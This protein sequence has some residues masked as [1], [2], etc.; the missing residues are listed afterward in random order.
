MSSHWDNMSKIYL[1]SLWSREP[2]KRPNNKKST[3]IL[4]NEF[5]IFFVGLLQKPSGNHQGSPKVHLV[6]AGQSGHASRGQR[7]HQHRWW[8]GRGCPTASRLENVAS[9][10]VLSHRSLG[11]ICSCISCYYILTINLV[12]NC[13]KLSVYILTFIVQVLISW[14]VTQAHFPFCLWYLASCTARMHPSNT[15]QSPFCRVQPTLVQNAGGKK[16]CQVY[17][18]WCWWTHHSTTCPSKHGQS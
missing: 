1:L 14:P 5:C 7:S 10:G 8:P 12:I 17:H 15:I 16:T 11:V 2:P 13:W 9:G 3:N 18:L 6:S 4:T